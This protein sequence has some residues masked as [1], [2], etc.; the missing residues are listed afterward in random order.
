MRMPRGATMP[1][2]A[3]EPQSPSHHPTHLNL[4]SPHARGR[5]PQ[6]TPRAR[7]ARLEVGIWVDAPPAHDGEH[8]VHEEALVPEGLKRSLAAC[9]RQYLLASRQE[10]PQPSDQFMQ[11]RHTA[12][13]R[14]ILRLRFATHEDDA[15]VD[16]R[17]LGSHDERIAAQRWRAQQSKRVGEHHHVVVQSEHVQAAAS[18]RRTSQ[19]QHEQPF[20]RPQRPEP[21]RSAATAVV[22]LKAADEGGGPAAARHISTTGQQTDA[23]PRRTKLHAR[24]VGVDEHECELA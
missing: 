19:A 21:R 14:A 6:Q 1:R 10:V 17:R 7:R 2:F 24:G 16:A 8:R 23:T 18:G 20:G 11:H 3:P 4:P 22:F 15:Q 13:H 12:R 9:I 5:P